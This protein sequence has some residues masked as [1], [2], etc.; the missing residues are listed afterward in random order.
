MKTS[1]SSGVVDFEGLV[2]HR[3]NPMLCSVVRR[4]VLLAYGAFDE[5]MRRS[6]D[7]DLWLR[8]AH[9][10]VRFNYT[11]RVVARYCVRAGGLTADVV[12]MIQGIRAVFEKCGRT[13]VLSGGERALLAERD[14]YYYA[15]ER[16]HEGKRAF[17]AENYPVARAAFDE[18]NL[19]LK[20][21][22]LQVVDALLATVP[23]LLSK[24]YLLRERLRGHESQIR[25]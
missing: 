16:L 18:A 8:L 14:R 24:L 13:L 25:S 10:G 22:K 9:G 11:T 19:M 23:R 12:A 17:L 5:S 4:R 20:S 7:F 6:E 3:C 15:L 21:R 2:T 1:P